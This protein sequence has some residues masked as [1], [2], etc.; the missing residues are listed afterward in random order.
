MQCQSYHVCNALN[1]KDTATHCPH[2]VQG[3]PLAG[4]PCAP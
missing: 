2:A 4:N 1:T 3:P